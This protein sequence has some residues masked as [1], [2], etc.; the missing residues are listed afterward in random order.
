MKKRYCFFHLSFTFFSSIGYGTGIFI[1]FM[2]NGIGKFMLSWLYIWISG[3]VIIL[4]IAMI[5]T[6]M[7]A[8]DSATNFSYNI[9]F[10]F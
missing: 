1:T 9:I 7:H 6:C 5:K 4:C 2:R 10:L 8:Y 3:Q